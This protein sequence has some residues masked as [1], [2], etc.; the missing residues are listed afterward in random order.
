MKNSLISFIIGLASFGASAQ[1]NISNANVKLNS[2]A[3]SETVADIDGN[4]YSTVIIG[5]QVWMKENL[6]T[7]RYSNGDAIPTTSKPTLDIS[8]ELKTDPLAA[9]D[10]S[11]PS[12]PNPKQS[13]SQLP[14]YQWAYEGKEEYA[15]IY[16]RLYTWYAASDERKVCP[17]GW[18]LP[19]DK[20]W[21][22]VMG[23]RGG[24]VTAGGKLK[25]EGTEH[26]AEPNVGATNE[27]G[28]SARGAGGRNPDGSFTGIGKYAAWWTASP[29]VYRHIEH[30][31]PYTF[32]NYYYSSPIYGFSIRCIK[33]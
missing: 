13:A 19:S 24:N 3:V 12:S 18:H 17:V 16:G 32:R 6:R 30:D 33:D 22:S 27:S 31:D 15:T 23:L 11:Q 26:W 29:A 20:D 5:S 2:N 8:S 4:I 9:K 28:F 25:E 10:Y 21:T 1:E 7:T 14:K